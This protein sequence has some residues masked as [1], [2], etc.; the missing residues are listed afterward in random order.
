MERKSTK[1]EREKERQLKPKK[2]Y[3]FNW[4]KIEKH[5]LFS[6]LQLLMWK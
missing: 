5:Y 4:N 6:L 3:K 1:K 2:I